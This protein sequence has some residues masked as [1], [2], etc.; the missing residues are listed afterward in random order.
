MSRKT[1]DL[2]IKIY[3]YKHLFNLEIKQV[4]GLCILLFIDDSYTLHNLIQVL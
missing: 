4:C 1:Y 3:N 2:C